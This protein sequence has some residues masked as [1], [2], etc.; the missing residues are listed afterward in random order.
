[1]ERI[2][3]NFEEVPQAQYIEKVVE[4]IVEMFVDAL[5]VRTLKQLWRK[6]LS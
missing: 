2:V 4:T 6:S 1:M 3:E 5:Q